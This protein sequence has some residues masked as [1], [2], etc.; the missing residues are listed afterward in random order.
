MNQPA[1]REGRFGPYGGAYV[2]ET[3][4]APLHEVNEAWERYRDDEEFNAELRDFL[5]NYV[6]RP[7]ALSR[8]PRLEEAWGAKG[9]IYFKRED[10][11]HTGAHKIN[12]SLGQALLAR[13]M[14]KQ[15]IIAE[16]GAG[17]HGVATATICARLGLECIVYMGE[18][19]MERQALNVFRMRMLGA[20]VR[21][22]DSGSRTLKDAIN[23]AMRDWVADPENTFY[24][25]GSAL[26]PHPYPTMVKHF[27]SVI[28][29]EA[30]AQYLEREGHLPSAVVACIGGGSNSIGIFSAFLDDED[31]KL[32]GGEAGGHG[33]DSGQHAARFAGGHPGILHGTRTWLLQDEA[34]QI[35]HTHSISAGLDYPAI[36]PEHAMLHDKGRA[37]YLPV[38]DDEALESFHECARLEGIF[39]ALESAHAVALAK[40]LVHEGLA[41]ERGLLINMSGRGD[42]DVHT[43]ASVEGVKLEN[44]EESA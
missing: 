15:R 38:N 3:L 6:G 30:R 7:S 16:T 29:T 33:V 31:V 25:I 42:K 4:H 27:Q 19:D 9:P 11:N 43:V 44:N 35:T 8:A 20:E 2:P 12:N 26:G 13:K 36:G 21:G 23:E 40:R 22:V 10:L 39:P 1:K 24:C 18:V 34:G 5:V 32:F 14:G 41:H 28:G 37:T 17:Q